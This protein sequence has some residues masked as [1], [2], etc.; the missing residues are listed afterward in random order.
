MIWGAVSLE[1]LFKTGDGFEK[2]VFLRPGANAI[3]A[4]FDILV[5]TRD[6]SS[7]IELRSAADV[8]VVSIK[9]REPWMRNKAHSPALLVS[10]TLTCTRSEEACKSE[11]DAAAASAVGR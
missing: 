6:P 4:R 10:K 1:S 3:V 5:N 7:T 2:T 9:R 11:S 8:S